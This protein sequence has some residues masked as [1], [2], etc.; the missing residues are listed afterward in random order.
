MTPAQI[1]LKHMP[2]LTKHCK[3]RDHQSRKKKHYEAEEQSLVKELREL[4]LQSE[5]RKQ[6]LNELRLRHVGVL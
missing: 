2:R 6:E 4:R 1:F 5:A 3:V